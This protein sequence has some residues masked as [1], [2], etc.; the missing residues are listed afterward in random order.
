MQQAQEGRAD[1]VMTSAMSE[2]RR[3]VASCSSGFGKGGMSMVYLTAGVSAPT[4]RVDHIGPSAGWL[5][6]AMSWLGRDSGV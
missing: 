6:G 1:L 3:H 4:P 2:T 5:Q